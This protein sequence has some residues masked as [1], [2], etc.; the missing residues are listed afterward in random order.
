MYQQYSDALYGIILRILKRQEDAEEVL[1]VVFLKIWNNI[2]SYSDTKATLF[3]WM[4]QIAR[5]AAI[6][7]SRLKS[8][9]M[10]NNTRSFDVS[11]NELKTEAGVAGIDIKAL[12]KD[13]PEKYRVLIEKMFLMGCTQQEIADDLEIPLGTVK[14]RLREAINQLRDQLKDEKHLLYSLFIM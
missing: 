6:D 9:E 5:N 12:I 13:M 11:E 7:R 2:D 3:T 8:F 10:D 1:Q 4:A 14:T